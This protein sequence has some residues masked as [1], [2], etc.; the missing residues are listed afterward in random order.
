MS[1]A[2]VPDD[3]MEVNVLCEEQL[4]QPD[5]E[6]FFDRAGEFYDHYTGE[7]LDRDA[8]TVAGIRAELTQMQEFGVFEWKRRTEKPAAVISRKVSKSRTR[9]LASHDVSVAFFHAWL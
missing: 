4:D 9:Q 5:V 2:P 1:A 3:A 7:G 8:T 6:T